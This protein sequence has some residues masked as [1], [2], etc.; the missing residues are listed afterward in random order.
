MH[1]HIRYGS[2]KDEYVMTFDSDN[3]S[4][5]DVLYEAK[6]RYGKYTCLKLADENNKILKKDQLIE[7]GRSYRV[8]RR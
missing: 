5:E 8:T 2:E 3:V 4:V 1:V 7:C 6:K